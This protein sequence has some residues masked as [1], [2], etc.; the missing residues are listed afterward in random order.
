MRHTN[1]APARPPLY[2]RLAARAQM[3][4]DFAML[5]QDLGAPDWYVEAHLD[6]S[7]QLWEQAM[8]ARPSEQLSLF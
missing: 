5:M 1:K 6:W 2:Q 7:C 8:S 4:E 3:T